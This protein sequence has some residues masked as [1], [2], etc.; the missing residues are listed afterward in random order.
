MERKLINWMGLL[1][2]ISLISYVLAVIISPMA[3]PGYNWME[4]SAVGTVQQ[5]RTRFCYMCLSVCCRQQSSIQA[6]SHRYI[7]LCSH[8]L[9][10][11]NGIPHVSSR[12]CRQRDS[13]I[14]GSHAYSCNGACSHFV[15]HFTCGSDNSRFQ[16]V[17]SQD[18]RQVGSNRT[19]HD[20]DWSNRN[21]HSSSAILRNSGKVQC[22]CCDRL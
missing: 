15:D 16:A 11:R 5:L 13:L 14:S 20:D 8:E 1:G 10:L 19:C 9:G 2:I 22:V 18:S 17:R 21:R 3:Y 4:G 6:V 12:G 7:S